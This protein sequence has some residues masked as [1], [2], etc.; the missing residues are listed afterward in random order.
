MARAS[1]GH[2]RVVS[3]A[4]V[5]A[6]K[7]EESFLPLERR[8]GNIRRQFN[9]SFCDPDGHFAITKFVAVCAQI[10]LLYHL[11]KDFDDLIARWESLAWVLT[12]L[13]A[14]DTIKKLLAMKYGGSNGTAVKP[15][16]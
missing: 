14:P 7:R 5:C 13:V 4:N 12:F 11:G 10:V 9:E 16:K 15:V 8:H 2:K 3:P 6:E 1:G